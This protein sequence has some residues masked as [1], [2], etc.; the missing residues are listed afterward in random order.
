[1]SQAINSQGLYCPDISKQPFKIE[2]KTNTC[3]SQNFLFPL[4]ILTPPPTLAI[5][6]KVPILPRSNIILPRPRQYV[7]QPNLA[8]T[9]PTMQSPAFSIVL[10]F[11]PLTHSPVCRA[12]SPSPDLQSKSSSLDRWKRGNFGA[13][14][15]KN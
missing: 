10:P 6:P 5:P 2:I 15:G 7:A 14:G 1:M 12:S 8:D 11:S 13:E 4:P 3:Q 9:S